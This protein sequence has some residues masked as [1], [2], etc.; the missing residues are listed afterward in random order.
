VPKQASKDDSYIITR[1]LCLILKTTPVGVPQG[2]IAFVFTYQLP[3]S[4]K[5]RKCC[6]LGCDY[7]QSVIR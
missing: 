6:L 7:V 1:Q 5:Y 4:H 2:N 3:L